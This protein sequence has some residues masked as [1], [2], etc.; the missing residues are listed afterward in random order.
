[1]YTICVDNLTSFC[2]AALRDSHGKINYNAV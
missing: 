2:V 1:M